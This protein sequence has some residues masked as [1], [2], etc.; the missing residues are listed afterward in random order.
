V[1]AEPA[2][3]I[4]WGRRTSLI[5][6]G[7]K[8]SKIEFNYCI[9]VLW[10]I[11][12]SFEAHSEQL[13]NTY[14]EVMAVKLPAIC[15]RFKQL[16]CAY[17]LSFSYMKFH[18]SLFRASRTHTCVRTSERQP[19]QKFRSDTME[20]E[21]THEVYIYIYAIFQ[22]YYVNTRVSVPFEELSQRE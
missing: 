10:C 17:I 3:G 11:M 5:S 1:R 16:W 6:E 8:V 2:Q 13:G 12:T 18:Q 22:L 15:G 20:P 21:V 7:V 14:R 4:Y 9:E 19:R